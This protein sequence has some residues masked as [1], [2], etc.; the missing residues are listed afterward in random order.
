MI[1]AMEYAKT[2]AIVCC[3]G[4]MAALVSVEQILAVQSKTP[5]CAV[6]VNLNLAVATGPVMDD[7]VQA[8]GQ[9]PMAYD[10]HH[11]P[12]SRNSRTFSSG[13]AFH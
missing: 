11:H 6:V 7:S 8:L 9:V 2:M 12:P 5:L 1:I 10:L 3:W 13:D 4:Q